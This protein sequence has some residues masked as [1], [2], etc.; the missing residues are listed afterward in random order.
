MFMSI[1][2]S[3]AVKYV[4]CPRY[5]N[6]RCIK[7]LRKKKN[8]PSTS[9][10]FYGIV[11]LFSLSL[12]LLSI[13]IYL[14][15]KHLD[16]FFLRNKI[17]DVYMELSM[18][19]F[20]PQ[21]VLTKA[22]KHGKILFIV[23]AFNDNAMKSTWFKKLVMKDYEH[24]DFVFAHTKSF[25]TESYLY[26]RQNVHVIE[27]N[28]CSGLGIIEA[29]YYF[30]N[31]GK[32]KWYSKI[33]EDYNCVFFVDSSQ[34]ISL[35]NGGSVDDMA[36]VLPKYNV[37]IVVPCLRDGILGDPLSCIEDKPSLN[38]NGES[39]CQLETMHAKAFTPAFYGIDTNL[40]WEIGQ[41]AFIN[42]IKNKDLS[43][44]F[45]ASITLHTAK[46]VAIFQKVNILN[47]SFD[48]ME[49]NRIY[50]NRNV[51]LPVRCSMCASYS[52]KV[53]SY[54][55]CEIAKSKLKLYHKIPKLQSHRY[56]VNENARLMKM[57]E[58]FIC[59]ECV[60]RLL[61]TVRT[62]WGKDISVISCKQNDN[63]FSNIHFSSVL[64]ACEEKRYTNF[65]GLVVYH[66]LTQCGIRDTGTN[67]VSPFGVV[68]TQ[69]TD[70]LFN[71]ESFTKHIYLP[72]VF[73]IHWNRMLEVEWKTFKQNDVSSQSNDILYLL[74]TSKGTFNL[75][76]TI[77]LVAQSHPNRK[78]IHRKVNASTYVESFILLCQQF[79][80]IIIEED[81]NKTFGEL[82]HF[83]HLALKLR[84]ITIYIGPPVVSLVFR[85]RNL[86]V[87]DKFSGIDVSGQMKDAL[88][89]DQTV[90]REKSILNNE[91]KNRYFSHSHFGYFSSLI[92]QSAIVNMLNRKDIQKQNLLRNIWSN[93]DNLCFF[94]DVVHD[95]IGVSN[96]NPDWEDQ[97]WKLLSIGDSLD[98]QLQNVLTKQCLGA[99][100]N[101]YNND[102]L[103]ISSCDR[104]SHTTFSIEVVA[105]F[106]FLKFGKGK[107]MSGN[108][109]GLYLEPC[110]LPNTKQRWE[111]IETVN[112]NNVYNFGDENK[113]NGIVCYGKDCKRLELML[114]TKYTNT[115]GISNVLMLVHLPFDI[116]YELHIYNIQKE[117]N[118]NVRVI[119]Y[120]RKKL[121][122]FIVRRGNASVVSFFNMDHFICNENLKKNIDYHLFLLKVASS[123]VQYISL[124]G[125]NRCKNIVN[126]PFHFFQ[127]TTNYE[128]KSLAKQEEVVNSDPILII[129]LTHKSDDLSH[130]LNSVDKYILLERNMMNNFIF[131][132]V[133]RESDSGRIIKQS[134]NLEELPAFLIGIYINETANNLVEISTVNFFVQN[135]IP[136]MF[137]SRSMRL[138]DLIDTSYTWNHPCI[139]E[140]YD[141]YQSFELR[142]KYAVK[143]LS[144]IFSLTNQNI[145]NIIQ[146]CKKKM[147]DFTYPSLQ[148]YR[149][150][151]LI[152][153]LRGSGF[154]VTK[155]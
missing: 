53:Y 154:R 16:N 96:C 113:T 39:I 44:N 121:N 4:K 31:Q 27:C 140:N 8:L 54:A 143:E 18:S 70:K 50:K 6:E 10:V 118:G 128:K 114:K 26:Q 38:N 155:K 135:R 69:C 144:R 152:S 93:N 3:N 145:L 46:K 132:M 88:S 76:A 64:H 23:K 75:Q 106:M 151:N 81:V 17:E 67:E 66:Y 45:I 150:K 21:R 57:A 126:F 32:R 1:I 139:D 2:P 91:I 22:N 124:G 146:C 74:D 25:E 28:H 83:V 24:I 63:A 142:R 42:K 116:L 9:V 72:N 36:Y 97:L 99:R 92:R 33:N 11:V 7:Q 84:S 109:D 73:H 20:L 148:E 37:D 78:I 112:L 95:G 111:I 29:Y 80:T 133:M 123:Q 49:E 12:C 71:F 68:I 34:Y 90:F 13:N 35:E 104:F 60:K 138:K 82:L 130:L 48:Y 62:I 120:L 61:T 47:Q 127:I 115:F 65:S 110:N 98:A 85:S 147:D 108:K 141:H 59:K 103:Y 52:S 107:C 14:Y 41:Y 153:I 149:K 15:N 5:C 79:K 129:A 55:S 117:P 137:V 77:R 122:E 56:E 101:I 125:I 105:S 87:I 102:I 43:A 30:R 134:L 40:L 58:V 94:H 119:L 136:F 100:K 131:K 51:S 19:P 86:F 89:G